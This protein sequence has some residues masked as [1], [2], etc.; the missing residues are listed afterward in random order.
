MAD[1]SAVYGGF[2]ARAI[3]YVIDYV[4]LIAVFLLVQFVTG[5]EYFEESDPEFDM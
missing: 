1:Q 5:A 4:I 2:G 3:A